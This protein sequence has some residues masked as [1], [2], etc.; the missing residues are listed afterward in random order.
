[1]FAPWTPPLDW[2]AAGHG[3]LDSA[4]VPQA[5]TG[6]RWA[7]SA[8]G[9][10]AEADSTLLLVP[11]WWPAGIVVTVPARGMAMGDT[12]VG[13]AT[14]LVADGRL[15]APTARVRAWRVPCR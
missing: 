11:P 8:D 4:R 6:R 10:G 14:A 5:P 12:I 1:M 9:A 15:T 3:A 7:L 2:S 13:R